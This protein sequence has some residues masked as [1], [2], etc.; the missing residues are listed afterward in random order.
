MSADPEESNGHS[1]GNEEASEKTQSG[2]CSPEETENIT[3]EKRAHGT[4]VRHASIDGARRNF[5]ECIAVAG[6]AACVYANSLHG[7]FVFDDLIA[8]VD[9]KDVQPS[10]PLN[11]VFSHDFWGQRLEDWQSHK[12]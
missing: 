1:A 11:E 6:L 7:D 10:T 12:A 3:M 4:T 9:N 8:I 5:G 2:R